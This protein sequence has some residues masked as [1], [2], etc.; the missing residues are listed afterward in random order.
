M[1]VFLE[2]VICVVPTLAFMILTYYRAMLCVYF[3]ITLLLFYINYILF[4]NIYL[5]QII[6]LML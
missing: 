2:P 6:Q 4:F 3:I 5:N 1:Y